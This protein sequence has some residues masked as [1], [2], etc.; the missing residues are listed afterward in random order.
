MAAKLVVCLWL[1]VI[2]LGAAPK[3]KQAQR[4]S[5]SP[6]SAKSEQQMAHD[7]ALANKA[8]TVKQKPDPAPANQTRGNAEIAV[9]FL[10]KFKVTDWLLVAFTGALVVVGIFQARRLR[11]SVDEAKTATKAAT[12]SADALVA[13]D[14]AYIYVD[15]SETLRLNAEKGVLN[16]LD[17]DRPIAVGNFGKTPAE[18][19][20]YVAYVQYWR[21]GKPS[22]LTGEKPVHGI[23]LAGGAISGAIPVQMDATPDEIVR[24]A[25]GEGSV[26]LIGRVKYRD[27]F[28]DCHETAFCWL[29]DF[30]LHKLTLAPGEGLNYNKQVDC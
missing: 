10:D 7:S 2:G 24:A 23:W 18:L 4:P 28:R 26:A 21:G 30:R 13:S 1:L 9:D 19:V 27:V 11:Q 22:D 29:W 12:R 15:T 20:S 16:A 25:S 17:K 14:R 5:N 3:Q 6:N 8:L